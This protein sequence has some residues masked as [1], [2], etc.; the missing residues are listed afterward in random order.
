M[1][2][3]IKCAA[4][5][6]T[7]DQLTIPYVRKLFKSPTFTKFSFGFKNDGVQLKSRV[8]LAEVEKSIFEQ[9]FTQEKIPK[10]LIQT[11]P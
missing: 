4:F 7:T 6:R 3:E 10:L 8:S 9:P 11:I 5:I 2:L 1:K